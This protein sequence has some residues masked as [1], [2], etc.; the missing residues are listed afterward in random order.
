M[1]NIK[2]PCGLAGGLMLEKQTAVFDRQVP[3]TEI[4]HASSKLGVAGG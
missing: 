2:K 1:G 3:A 4:N